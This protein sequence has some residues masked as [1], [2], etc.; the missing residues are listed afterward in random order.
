LFYLFQA[1]TEVLKKALNYKV[2]NHRKK[3]NLSE[4]NKFFPF[5]QP[6]KE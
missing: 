2:E 5:W 3:I 1:L 6:E 4:F